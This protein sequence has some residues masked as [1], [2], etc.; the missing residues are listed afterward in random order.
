MNISDLRFEAKEKSEEALKEWKKLVSS[1]DD[2]TI[3]SSSF[4][5]NIFPQKSICCFVYLKNE[6]VSGTIGY[7]RG[8]RSIL[9]FFAKTLW[10]DAGILVNRNYSEHEIMIKTYLLNKLKEVAKNNS[11]IQVKIGQWN[12]ERNCE[13]FKLASYNYENIKLYEVNL[14]LTENELFS[15]INSKN[16]TKIRKSI[17][18]KVKIE[19]CNRENSKK[20]FAEFYDLYHATQTRAI[21]RYKNVGVTIKSRDFLFK[22]IDNSQA[23][24]SIAFHKHVLS[25]AV[26]LIPYNNKICGYVGA[27]N[28]EINRLTASSNLLH[29]NII[30]WYKKQGYS[31][32]ELGGP[33]ASE[34]NSPAYSVY[35]FKKGF[36]G[37]IYEYF[38]GSYIISNLK[39]SIFNYFAKYGYITRLVTKIFE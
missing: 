39:C 10:I 5:Y 25:S 35:R 29:W 23:F 12:R 13:I 28:L 38:F 33:V 16:R 27:S 2:V 15:R 18:N 11:C 26:L 7:F 37:D 9:K 17:K 36:N 20:Y 30:L 34:I 22:L 4:C 6:L 32:Y 19:H 1:S 14:N 31:R 24:L 8:D 21:H 3:F